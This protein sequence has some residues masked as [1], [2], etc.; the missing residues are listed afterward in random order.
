M[1]G[2]NFASGAITLSGN[3]RTILQTAGVAQLRGSSVTW[4][5]EQTDRLL[6]GYVM[7]VENGVVTRFGRGGRGTPDDP[8]DA[9]RLVLGSDRPFERYYGDDD[10]DQRG[11]G[12]R[13][14][15][16]ADYWR[17]RSGPE[18]GGESFSKLLP[19]GSIIVSGPG[20]G[21]DVQATYLGLRVVDALTLANLL[22]AVEA[23][24][25]GA[26]REDGGGL[27]DEEEHPDLTYF[28][29]WID[30]TG[31]ERFAKTGPVVPLVINPRPLTIDPQSYLH[32]R[33]AAAA[34]PAAQRSRHRSGR[35]RQRRA[36][37]ADPRG[38]ARNRRHPVGSRL[39]HRR[40]RF[41]AAAA[42]RRR[43]V[44]VYRHRHHR[45]E[46]QQLRV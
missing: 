41:W 20:A 24:E 29:Y 34:D 16:V 23:G 27:W 18:P 46:G 42:H 15:S 13:L 1:R 3:L 28:G 33:F 43:D 44:H 39:S 14:L 2:D 17:A 38:L 45:R 8:Y 30:L 11:L 21:A 25:G 5:T 9:V 4:E 36:R 22:L 10:P 35:R 7:F 19:S 6:G 26:A 40:R 32:L 12:D 31:G 37:P